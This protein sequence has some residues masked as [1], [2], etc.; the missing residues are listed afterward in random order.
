MLHSVGDRSTV[1]QAGVVFGLSMA[2]VVTRGNSES[3]SSFDKD[4]W[5]A[6]STKLS[7]GMS[8][9]KISKEHVSENHK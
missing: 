8:L 1:H 9:L 3:R 7:G 6:K 4:D 2:T 5:R